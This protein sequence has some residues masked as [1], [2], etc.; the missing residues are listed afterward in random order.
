M[1]LRAE[2]DL[3]IVSLRQFCARAWTAK[4]RFSETS[5]MKKKM[6]EARNERERAKLAVEIEELRI[7]RLTK[8]N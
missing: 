3:Q 2:N 6:M 8:R 5:E 4:R 1:L 7:A